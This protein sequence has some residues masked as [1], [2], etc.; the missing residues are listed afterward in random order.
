MCGR[1]QQRL[2]PDELARLYAVQAA[3]WGRPYKWPNFNV[4]PRQSIAVVHLDDE[5]TRTA[6]TM[7]WGFP[8]QWVKRKGKD[9]FQAPPLVNARAETALDKRTWATALRTRR[10]L[11]PTTGFYEW[12]RQGRKALYPYHITRAEPSPE[13]PGLLT[14]AGVWGPF[15]WGDDPDKQ[16]WPCAAILTVAP[17]SEVAPVHD[18]CPLVLAPEQWAAWLDPDTPEADVLAMLQPPADGT[19]A[20]TPVS[21]TLNDRRANGPDTQVADWSPEAA[22]GP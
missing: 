9:P 12:I 20:L 4:A 5:G 14:L 1:Y 19:L 11:V 22:H 7:R 21:T 3:A 16:A 15:P 10:C 13:A 8:P 2:G 6:R 18:R 17:P